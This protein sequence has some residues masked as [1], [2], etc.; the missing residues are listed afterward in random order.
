MVFSDCGEA[1]FDFVPDSSQET[2]RGWTVAAGENWS[3]LEVEHAVEDYMRMLRFEL[4]RQTYN[5]AAHRRALLSH[6]PGRSK[7]AVELKHQNISAVLQD[8]S[9]FWIPGYKPRGNYQNMLFEEVVAW[10]N[11]NTDFERHVF[12]AAM[13][14]AEPLTHIDFGEFIVGKPVR[15]DRVAEVSEPRS[16]DRRAA[17]QTRRRDYFI[18]EAHNASLGAAGETM[19]VRFEQE[20]LS[21]AGCE[22]LAGKV[23]HVSRTLG[24]GVGFDVLSYETTGAERLIEVK[25]TSFA[26]ETP[27]YASA[28]EVIFARENAPRYHL[29]RLFEFRSAPKCFVL[30][31][32][33]DEHCVLDASTYRCA[34]A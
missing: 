15:R 3:K 20:R 18:Q 8:L 30:R 5:K 23:E 21:R 16:F 7:G 6:L 34:F 12:D 1:W 29:Y 2:W 11:R 26:K 10:L 25:T 33:L 17:H 4:L 9:M 24:D 32:A 14:H 22:G 27:F 31:G 19:V 13:A 28:A